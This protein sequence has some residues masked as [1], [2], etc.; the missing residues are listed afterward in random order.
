MFSPYY[1]AAAQSVMGQNRD[2]LFLQPLNVASIFGVN[3]LAFFGPVTIVAATF[4]LII[5]RVYKPLENLGGKLVFL[6][7]GI[8]PLFSFFMLV[9]GIGEMNYWWFN[10]RFMIMLAPLLI[11]LLSISLKR[12]NDKIL[13]YKSILVY[14]SFVIFLIYPIV[15]LP[16]SGQIVT[17]IDASDSMSYGSRPYAM[18]LAKVL[19]GL[20]D[21]G[22]IF[23]I[24]G[25]A[26][27]N[28]IMQASGIPL[29]N[30][31]TASEQFKTN[32]QLQQFERESHFVI[33]SKA[34]EADSLAYFNFWTERQ[35]ELRKYFDNVYENPIYV[36]FVSN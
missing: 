23:I 27:Q 9:F 16:V 12:I 15:M 5:H 20:Y 24:A 8:P 11:L 4:G 2:L 32:Q 18:N 19:G 6:F 7:L 1:S 31:Y 34:P 35:G 13:R 28:I 29:T 21:G 17:L 30:F 33:L 36:L 22:K 25:S 10:S 3:A 14:V 26:Q